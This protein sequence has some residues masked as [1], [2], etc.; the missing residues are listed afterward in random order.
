M[1]QSP[2]CALSSRRRLFAVSGAAIWITAGVGYLTLEAVAAVGFQPSY[3]YVRDYISDLGV[4]SRGVLPG[5]M[6]DSPLAYLMNTA[7]YLQGI[8]FLVGAV[9]VVRAAASQ[10]AGL[11]LTLAAVNAVGNILVGTFHAG[12]IAESDG[13]VWVHRAGAVLAIVGGNMA[14]LAGSAIVRSAG[15]A[16]WYRVASLGFAAVGLLSFLM[17]IID[18]RTGAVNV[19]PD[20]VWERG[21]VYSIILW[22][23]FTA[24]YLVHPNRRAA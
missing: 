1:G 24:A 2:E 19:L 11:F 15:A 4:T 22:Q 10:K 7:F 17:L 5:R 9:L 14:I 12:P 3:S 16:Q 23:M 18:S 21:S 20:G 13:T 6:I 8:F